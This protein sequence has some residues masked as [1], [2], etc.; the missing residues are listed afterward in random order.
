MIKFV[1]AEILSFSELS[2]FFNASCPSLNPNSYDR[3]NFT[4]IASTSV[5]LAF[6]NLLRFL[7]GTVP[8]VHDIDDLQYR[9][10]LLLDYLGLDDCLNL[11]LGLRNDL[12]IDYCMS[13]NHSIVRYDFHTYSSS[14]HLTEVAFSE[15]MYSLYTVRKRLEELVSS[16]G[17]S[18]LKSG[19]VAKFPL[20]NNK[21]ELVKPDALLKREYDIR[22][23]GFDFPRLLR[24]STDYHNGTY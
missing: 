24:V 3:N 15:I 22:R 11:L 12:D 6:K 18:T 9:V 14:S 1:D 8:N 4:Y 10:S 23:R 17:F 19:A 2:S 7:G 13:L 5:E 16:T 21:L 20:V